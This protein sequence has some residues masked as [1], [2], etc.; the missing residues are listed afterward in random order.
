MDEDDAEITARIDELNREIEGLRLENEIFEAHFDRL[1]S[2]DPSAAEHLADDGGHKKAK[3]A[4]ASKARAARL[5]TRLTMEQKVEISTAEL[6][7]LQVGASRAS[8]A[9][10]ARS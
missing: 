5:P 7:A 2:A 6:E 1:A 10:R 3:G 9:P 8:R 4:G